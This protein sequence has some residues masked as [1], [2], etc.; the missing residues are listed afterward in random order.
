MDG[1]EKIIFILIIMIIII[2]TLSCNSTKAKG[3]QLPPM[4]QAISYQA[5]CSVQVGIGHPLLETAELVL[6]SSL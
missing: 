3:V 1:T 2:Q 6:A 5:I 4:N